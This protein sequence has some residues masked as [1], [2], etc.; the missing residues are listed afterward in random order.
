MQCQPDSARRLAN[1][2]KARTHGG[3]ND[4]CDGGGSFQWGWRSVGQRVK[5]RGERYRMG[6]EE[7]LVYKVLV[8]WEHIRLG[9]WV[10]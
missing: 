1:T 5:R 6:T 8:G 7:S 2:P 10:V 9:L 3:D 4:V